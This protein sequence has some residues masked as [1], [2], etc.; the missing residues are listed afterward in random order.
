[1]LNNTRKTALV[2]SSTDSHQ[3]PSN[4]ASTVSKFH[5]SKRRSEGKVRFGIDCSAT[6]AALIAVAL[7]T[8]L[9]CRPPEKYARFVAL[10][11]AEAEMLFR[12]LPID[13]QLDTYVFLSTR[14]EPPKRGYADFIAERG[15]PAVPVILGR[16]SHATDDKIRERLILILGSMARLGYY[17]FRDDPE[18]VQLVS[19]NVTGMR[20]DFQRELA[21]KSL[22]ELRTASTKAN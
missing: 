13:E 15:R 17:D 1:M 19:R 3:T 20:D 9:T 8:A 21:S 11:P 7:S 12:R 5:M 14:I 22:G 16:L 6:K 18:A 4:T 10:P 2:G